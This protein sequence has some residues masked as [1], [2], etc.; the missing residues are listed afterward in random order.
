[1]NV[2]TVGLYVVFW[3]VPEILTEKMWDLKQIQSIAFIGGTRKATLQKANTRQIGQKKYNK[4]S[5]IWS[6]ALVG[7]ATKAILW[8][9]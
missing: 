8:Q 7:E 2:V 4:K 6:S 1:M 5:K 9:K 3:N